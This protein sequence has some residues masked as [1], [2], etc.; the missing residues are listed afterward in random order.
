M[1]YNFEYLRKKEQKKEPIGKWKGKE[2]H[3]ISFNN[4]THNWIMG[5]LNNNYY[6]CIYDD[7]NYLVNKNNIEGRLYEDGNVD[8][9]APRVYWS[10]SAP[11]AAKKEEPAAVEMPV[12]ANTVASGSVELNIASIIADV[13]KLL[14]SACSWT[15]S[16]EG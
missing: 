6:Y 8:T 13:D 1:S 11:K 16:A 2:V 7:N 14:A 3:P 5:Y 15:V 4:Y 9:V 12:A 10:P